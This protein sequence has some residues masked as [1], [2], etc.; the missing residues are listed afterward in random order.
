MQ[1]LPGYGLR[2]MTGIRKYMSIYYTENSKHLVSLSNTIRTKDRV[3]NVSRKRKGQRREGEKSLILQSG[4]WG[5]LESGLQGSQQ[6]TV[7]GTVVL[8]DWE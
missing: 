3:L 7:G 4:R 2:E 6:V 5:M 1:G 8:G